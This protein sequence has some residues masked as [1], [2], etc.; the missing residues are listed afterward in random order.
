RQEALTR[1]ILSLSDQQLVT[2]LGILVAAVSNQCTLSGAEFDIA[3]SLA[4]FSATVH[5]VA[6]DVLQ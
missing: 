4:W 6:L 1:F 3:L 5:L 2:G